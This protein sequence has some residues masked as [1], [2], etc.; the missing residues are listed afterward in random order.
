MSEGI[1]A[2]A[3]TIAAGAAGM[4]ALSD[5][6]PEKPPAI[7]T[8]SGNQLSDKSAE[9]RA[10]GLANYGYQYYQAVKE[11]ARI[12]LMI[13]VLQQAAG[14]YLADK[15]H[16]TAKQAQRRFDEIWHN[17]KDKS[18]KFF[19]HW[20]EN[21]R[22][23]EIAMLNEARAREQRGYQ[24]DYETAKNR[25]ITTSRSEFAKAREKVM[26]ESR[27]HCVGASRA[28]LRQ[29]HAA[30]ARAVVL[31]TNQAI[32]MEEERKH[33]RES[34]YR[35]ESY[36]WIGLTQ[37]RIGDSYRALTAAQQAAGEVSKLDPYAGWAQSIGNLSNIGVGIARMNTADFGMMT[38]HHL[39]NLVKW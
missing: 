25:A 3:L 33:Q 26:R 12:N 9:L 34:Q 21:G 30:E 2:A 23:L 18:D 8:A 24:V 11:N 19:A 37:G 14:F 35:E 22:P 27:I 28:A 7:G 29:L 4:V 10:Q 5:N 20:W 6:P 38:S 31:A 16:D 32:R 17:Q 39:P 15:Q 36:K 1:I 13:G